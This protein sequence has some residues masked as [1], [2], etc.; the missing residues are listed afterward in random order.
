MSGTLK[1][2]DLAQRTGITA[3]TIR[4]YESVG[5]LHKPVRSASGYRLYGDRD[6][7]RLLFIKKAKSLGFSLSDIGE[8]LSI[9]KSQQAPCVHVL[10]LLDRKVQEIERLVSELTQLQQELMNLRDTSAVRIEQCGADGSICAIVESS[11]ADITAKGQTALT[12]LEARRV[13]TQQ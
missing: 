9:Y 1:I 12:W 5:L 6:V 4:Y 7:E 10:S 11:E 3:R 2:G 13:I 8:I